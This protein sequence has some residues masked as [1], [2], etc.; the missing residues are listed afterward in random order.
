VLGMVKRNF[1]DRSK[2]T[3][4]SS[5]KSLVRPH[6]EISLLSDLES[7]LP[8]DARVAR[9]CYR[10]SSVPPSVRLSVRPSVCDVEVPWAYRVD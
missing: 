8:R 10:K 7:S 1:V 9:Y 3:I 4:I 2:E 5:Y 6:L